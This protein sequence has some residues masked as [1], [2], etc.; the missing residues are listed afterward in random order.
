MGERAVA[1]LVTSPGGEGLVTHATGVKQRAHHR[2][3]Y[4]RIRQRVSRNQVQQKL[5]KMVS[6]DG[7]FSSKNNK[8]IALMVLEIFC[9]LLKKSE[10]YLACFCTNPDQ[11]LNKNRA[12]ERFTI[13][14][15]IANDKR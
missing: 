9:A 8:Y 2:R 5:L 7:Y 15:K 13:E 12:H 1:G 6:Q 10:T 11:D 3:R 14:E 4:R